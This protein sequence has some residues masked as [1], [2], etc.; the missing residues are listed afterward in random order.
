MRPPMRSY[1]PMLLLLLPFLLSTIAPAALH[2]DETKLCA[3][4]TLSWTSCLER[5]LEQEKKTLLTARSR[6]K[7]RIQAESVEEV[8]AEISR[9]PTSIDALDGSVGL[10]DFLPRF[11]AAL[12]LGNFSEE[13]GAVTLTFN[14][15]LLVF[16]SSK[17]SLQAVQHDPKL[18]ATL[19][20]KAPEADR[21]ALE[22]RLGDEIENLDDF[23]A[24]LTWTLENERLGRN[25][26][27]HETMLDTLFDNAYETA[28]ETAGNEA[29]VA[30]LK[31]LERFPA[32][33][34]GGLDEEGAPFRI[35]KDAPDIARKVE[36][37]MFA[38]AKESATFDLTLNASLENNG[39]YRLADLVNNQPQLYFTGAYRSKDERVGPDEWSIQGVYELP[40]GQSVNKLR[41]HSPD[42][43]T[44]LEA[45]GA[46]FKASD[47]AGKR[48]HRL[49]LKGKYSEVGAY[50]SPI[51]EVTL[52]L[53]RSR[54]SSFS[55]EYGYQLWA[56]SEE[57]DRVGGARIEVK[58]NWDDASDNPMLNDRFTASATFT[59]GLFDDVSLAIGAVYANKPEYR[60]T[61]DKELSARF[62]L[63]FKVDRNEK[64][65][66]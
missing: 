42:A 58:A 12:G 23:E 53:E 41:K 17:L 54:V 62:G 25:L 51:P 43:G 11:A 57:D 24:K 38:A 13:D 1:S 20:V 50:E 48:G 27:S 59:Q 46:Y 66:E 2:A 22:E 55:L 26:R 30:L 52:D 64:K 4:E 56:D 65:K 21:K 19:L 47:D 37:A 35:W 14:P 18:F 3:E 31:I 32:G 10:R 60:D 36:A 45:L 39:F 8:A 9:K 5:L 40:L 16:G 15:E 7:S 29:T 28:E 6:E 61:V 49:T 33:T 63:R 44:S 34:M